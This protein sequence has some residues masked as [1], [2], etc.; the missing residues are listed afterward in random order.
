MLEISRLSAAHELNNKLL[1]ARAERAK[2]GWETEYIVA[3]VDSAEAALLILDHYAST[4][5]AGIHE[6][7]V[8]EAY[9][10][11]EVG[12]ALLKHAET[13]A[14]ELCCRRIQLEVHPLD[15]S[16][17]KDSLRAWYIRYGY[18]EDTDN[19]DRLCKVLDADAH[20]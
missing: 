15:A 14:R 5:T 7:F 11:A 12:T 3:R 20:T 2:S 9:R 10:K 4:Q 1:R 19:P 13:R 8:L 17:H 16:I 6:I 18:H